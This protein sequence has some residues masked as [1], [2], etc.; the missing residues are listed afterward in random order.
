MGR[1]YDLA[2]VGGGIVGLGHAVAALRRGLTVAVVDRASSVEGA[3]VR[4]F[5]HLCITG[6]EGEARAY[7]ELGRELWLTLAVEAGFWL[8]EVGTVVVAQAPDELAVLEEFRDTR[9][10]HDV[11]MLTPADVRERVPVADGV[12][13][14]GAFF[15]ADLQVDPREAAPAIARW[16]DAHGVDFF[17]QTT[18][19]GVE[20]GRVH[21][22]RGRVSADAVVVAVDHEVDRLFPGIAEAHGIQRCGLDM[23][24]VEADFERPLTAPVLTARSLVGAAGFA[25]TPGVDALRERLATERPDL[26]AFDIDQVFAQRPDG[27]VILGAARRCGDDVPPFQSE[28]AFEL[29]LEGARSLFGLGRVRIL[30]RWQ[31]VHAS[32]ADDFLV[33]S[34]A[35]SVRVVSVTSGIG[36]TSGLGLADRVVDELFATAPGVLTAAGAARSH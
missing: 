27:S 31:G 3:S 29:L 22:S 10:G 5:G 20:T 2:I 25:H 16:L 6:Q 30:E 17:W 4:G 35:P 28:T 15:P 23:L 18:V 8:G 9:G 34:P 32:A 33:S 1:H 19:T 26:A 11:R 12:A 7:A 24:L 13:V 36:M 21:T 14:G